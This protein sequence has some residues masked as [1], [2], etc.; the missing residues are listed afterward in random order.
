MK[1]VIYEQFGNPAEVLKVVEEPSA[2]LQD[3][4][5]RVEVLR[6]PINPS[7]LIQI[8]G[9]YGVKPPLP[10]VAGNEGLVQITVRHRHQMTRVADDLADPGTLPGGQQYQLPRALPFDNPA[11]PFV[12]RNSR[13]RR[14]HPI[15]T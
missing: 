6:C 9:N 3:G 13:Q 8:S 12:A 10:A 11:Q 5:V 14:F 7:D 1:K 15:V 2:P 4:Q